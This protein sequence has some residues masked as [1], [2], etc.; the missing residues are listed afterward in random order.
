M[1]DWAFYSL[2]V[3]AGLAGL[4]G[5]WW[6]L[7]SDRSRGRARCQ[8]CWYD[9]S[10][11]V[12]AD[13]AAAPTCPECGRT[14]KSVKRLYRTRRRWR[15]AGI[16]L[17][18]VLACPALAM[19][20]AIRRDG[21]WSS[22]PTTV[23][24]FTDTLFPAAEDS[25]LND[26]LS[27]RW[28]EVEM[29]DWQARYFVRRTLSRRVIR[30]HW[31]VGMQAR[32]PSAF[33]VGG[34]RSL[35][36]IRVSNAAP[37]ETRYP[38]Y[39][40]R[41]PLNASA[42]EFTATWGVEPRQRAVHLSI[43]LT[44]G[45]SAEAMLSPESARPDNATPPLNDQP[46]LMR[47]SRDGGLEV[48]PRFVGDFDGPTPPGESFSTVAQGVVLEVFRSDKFV[49]RARWTTWGGIRETFPVFLEG[50]AAAVLAADP[51]DPAW[52][53]I[54]R[55]DPEMAILDIYAKT[56]WVGQYEIPMRTFMRHVLPEKP[57]PKT[58][59]QK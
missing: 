11:L 12:P 18:F 7:F 36:W 55:D 30:T 50:D 59:P 57:S 37:S 34:Q 32:G 47:S 29:W 35:V 23:L 56:R 53:V 48:Q 27:A 10:S 8:R 49:A 1:P 46:F 9:L 58:D 15:W 54:V 28:W 14:A 26:A 25:D 17:L 4:A 31:P 24:I 38:W 3:L 40:V 41:L 13:R 2:A 21:F 20:P 42:I 44:Y 6:S 22:M 16:A 33:G 5:L 51:D 45:G 52:K 39:T 43:P 19:T